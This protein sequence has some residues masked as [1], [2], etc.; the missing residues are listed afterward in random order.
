MSRYELYEPLYEKVVIV[1]Q[2]VGRLLQNICL[3]GWA[4]VQEVLA[5]LPWHHKSAQHRSDRAR[6]GGRQHIH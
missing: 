6:V 1:Q 5:Q 2:A 3:A 4:I